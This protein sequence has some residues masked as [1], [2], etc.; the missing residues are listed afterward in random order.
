MPLKHSPSDKAFK[1]NLKKLLSEGY[2][3]AQALAIAFSTQ[4]TAKKKKK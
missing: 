1:E 4:R 3:K 2:S